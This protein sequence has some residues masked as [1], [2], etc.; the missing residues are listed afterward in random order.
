MKVFLVPVFLFFQLAAMGQLLQPQDSVERQAFSEIMN[1]LDPVLEKHFTEKAS[2]FADIFHDHGVYS[3]GVSRIVGQDA[4]RD[5]F[6]QWDRRAAVSFEK[7]NIDFR[8]IDQDNVMISMGILEGKHGLWLGID[9]W[10][11]I[12]GRWGVVYSSWNY[13]N[14]NR[15]SG[16][17]SKAFYGIIVMIAV[18]LMLG[19]A[20]GY[21]AHRLLF[22]I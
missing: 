10:T 15:I 7:R 16:L 19:V 3:V 17:S 4:I 20:V 2:A 6:S 9:H 18:V 21:R 13:K 5:R 14:L 8:Y 11:R 1:I 12:D 22:R